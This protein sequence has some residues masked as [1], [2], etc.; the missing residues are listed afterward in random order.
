VKLTP[1]FWAVNGV[2]CR[3]SQSMRNGHH[4]T[5]R[6]TPQKSAKQIYSELDALKCAKAAGSTACL[7]GRMRGCYVMLCA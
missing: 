1:A 2:C 7:P 3:L 6:D 5:Q 4:G